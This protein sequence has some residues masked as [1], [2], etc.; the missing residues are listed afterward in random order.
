MT[1][2]LVQ[3]GSSAAFIIDKPI[4]DLL[5]VGM[6]TPLE[7]TTNGLSIAISPAPSHTEEEFLASIDKI[8]SQFS[9]TLERFEK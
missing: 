5:K 4:L 6:D 3:H 9:S 2:K 8:N 1:K 7:I